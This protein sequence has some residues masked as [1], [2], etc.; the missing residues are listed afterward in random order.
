MT[1]EEFMKL[2]H[3]TEAALQQ[4]SLNFAAVRDM[5]LDRRVLTC[6]DVDHSFFGSF[7]RHLNAKA[8]M[9]CHI[10][11]LVTWSVDPTMEVISE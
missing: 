11:L 6:V 3:S 8:W 1:E 9:K 5:N 2:T 7:H 10:S 4:K